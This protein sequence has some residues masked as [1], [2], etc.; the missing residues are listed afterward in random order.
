MAAVLCVDANPAM[1]LLYRDMFLKER[2]VRVYTAGSG[3]QA[4]GILGG[5]KGIDALVTERALC[6]DD[7]GIGLCRD[8]VRRYRIPAGLVHSAYEDKV[9]CESD[10]QAANASGILEKPFGAQELRSF[11]H[12]LLVQREKR[13]PRILIV[14]DDESTLTMYGLAFEGSGYDV[15]TAPDGRKALAAVRKSHYDIV[16]TDIRMPNMSGIELAKRLHSTVPVIIGSARWE[17]ED[18]N[19]ARQSGAVALYSKPF[20]VL[21]LVRMVTKY[22]PALPNGKGKA[23]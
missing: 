4:R 18:R 14:D 5:T 23:L 22:F 1:Q 19:N 16:L 17:D 21:D 6:G 13:K 9:L 11:V 20:P 8:A 12:G 15:A 10:L 2:S 7:D 3:E